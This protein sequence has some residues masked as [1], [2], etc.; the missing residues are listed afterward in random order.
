MPGRAVLG[1]SLGK[2]PPAWS[3]SIVRPLLEHWD[4]DRFG[5][6]HKGPFWRWE[7]RLVNAVFAFAG[8]EREI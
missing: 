1:D 4:G 7:H 5:D 8:T 6:I 2:R 3:T